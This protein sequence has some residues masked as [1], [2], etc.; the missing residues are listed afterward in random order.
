MNPYFACLALLAASLTA[1][2][3]PDASPV[4]TNI[5]QEAIVSVTNIERSAHF[6]TAIGGY[7]EKW[8]GE[9]SPSEIEAWG[10][11]ADA[12]GEALLLGPA[13]QTTGLLRL[14]R[15]DNAGRK[16][17]TR[18]GS[19][20]WDTG[21]YFSVMVRMK[22][23]P[24]IYDD[25]VAMGWWTETPITKLNFGDSYL[26]VTVFQGPDGMQVQGY[27]RLSL[28][29]PEGFPEFER[30]SGPF[31]IMQ[32]VSDRDK[33]YS[34]FTEVLGFA[35]FYRG[36]PYVSPEPVVMP[37]GIP[38]NLTTSVRYRAGI[39]YPVPGEFG[40]METIEIMDLEGSD[41]A[42]RC[43]AP[44][45]GILAVRFPVEHAEQ[46]AAAIVERGWSIDKRISMV[47]VEPYGELAMFSIKT[48][49]GANIQFFETQAAN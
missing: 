25:A 22:N 10:L 12:S 33:S 26:N 6:F 36:K 44:N 21:C 46:A 14:V 41:Y 45:L 35:T 37:L 8:R 19:R 23:M 34:F 9:I 30:F 32:M 16:E 13:G 2:A 47:S 29:L 20:A 48:P 38:R 42:E 18:P 17:P 39:V 15:F 49:D 5:W 40:R 1:L 24:S 28:P 31:N 27:E 11:S 3:E 43:N 4:T 7:E